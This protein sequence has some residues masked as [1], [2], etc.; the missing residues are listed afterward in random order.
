VRIRWTRRADSDLYTAYDFIAQDD[1]RAAARTIERIRQATAHLEKQPRMGRFGE[2]DG[3]HELVVT[4]TPFI[5]IYRLAEGLIEILRVIHGAQ[6]W[7][8]GGA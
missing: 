2:L 3:T 4:G 5:V 1:R 6:K 8:D 7:P